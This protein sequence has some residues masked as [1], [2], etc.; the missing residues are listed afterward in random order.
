MISESTPL[1]LIGCGNMGSALA[2]GWRRSGIEPLIIIDSDEQKLEPFRGDADIATYASI[3]NTLGTLSPAAIGLATKPNG[4]SDALHQL[5][6]QS[7]GTPPLIFS[8]AAGMSLS[9]Y[10]E[11]LWDNTPIVRVMPNLP[12]T[13]DQGMSICVANSHVSPEQR[14]LVRELFEAVGSVL[15]LEDESLMDAVTAISGSGPAYVFY[16]MEAMIN[17]SVAMGLSEKDA[18]LLVTQTVLGSAA[19]AKE[20][21]RSV[22]QL[23]EAVTSPEGTTAAAL[24]ILKSDTSHS[25]ANII[26]RAMQAA[27]EKSEQ[28]RSE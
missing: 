14:K 6:E 3:D 5:R 21:T 8:I 7:F 17:E 2:H 16:M 11:K 23:R 20:S 19:L 26:M 10:E 4:L 25:F 13:I 9:F 22:S 18:T 28:I 15:W 24:E 12:S 1:A 27:K